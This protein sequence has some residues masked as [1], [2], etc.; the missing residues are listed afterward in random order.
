[1]RY[2][3][4]RHVDANWLTMRGHESEAGPVEEASPPPQPAP[5]KGAGE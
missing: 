1:M 2:V 3:M 5:V 4:V